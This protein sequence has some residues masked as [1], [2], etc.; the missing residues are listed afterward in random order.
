MDDD[1]E[2]ALGRL[3]APDVDGQSLNARIARK[4]YGRR[5]LRRDASVVQRSRLIR[6]VVALRII[7][8]ECRR[9]ADDAA[10]V[11][12]VVKVRRTV[13]ERR[14][15]RHGSGRAEGEADSRGAVNGVSACLGLGIPCE[16]IVH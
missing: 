13:R 9:R 3:E 6:R 15:A 14:K 5:V 8:E 11:Q 1:R 2:A 10:L 12:R 4:V 16:D 7:L